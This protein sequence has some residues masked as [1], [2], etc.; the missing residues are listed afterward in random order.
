M[1]KEKKVV[2]N[3]TKRK[4]NEYDYTYG[5][6][7]RGGIQ[8]GYKNCI[9]YPITVPS[10]NSYIAKEYVINV[11]RINI[12]QYLYFREL[13]FRIGFFTLLF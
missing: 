11:S 1:K 12:I 10:Y 13:C 5:I 8:C 7:N 6:N 9:D 2:A 3:T 4:P